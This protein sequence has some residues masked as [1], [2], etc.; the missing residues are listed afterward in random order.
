MSSKK[1]RANN[2]RPR[3][4]SGAGSRKPQN[5]SIEWLPLVILLIVG[6]GIWAGCHG[7]VKQQGNET[8]RGPGT[9]ELPAKPVDQ[10]RN[11]ASEPNKPKS[12]V[13]PS[14]SDSANSATD[15]NNEHGTFDPKQPLSPVDAGSTTRSSRPD[16]PV[17][18]ET[19]T[20]TAQPS[21]EVSSVPN[22]KGMIALTFDAGASAEPVAD[23]L[24]ALADSGSHATFFFTG[25][26]VKKN[27]EAAKSIVAAGHE[28]GNHSWSHPDFT[29]LSDDEMLDQLNQTQQILMSQLGIPGA[30]L[31]RPPFGARNKDVRRLVSSQGYRI[32]YWA[33]DCLDSVKKNITSE[34]IEARVLARAKQGDVVLM[35]CGSQPTADALPTL[36][37]ALKKKG[38]RLVTVG[39]LLK[40]E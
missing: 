34:Q 13:Q 31:F 20:R 9:V 12:D 11:D 28:I 30:A 4:R 38:L 15:T 27:P 5:S 24:K 19:S 16:E 2:T 7:K 8:Y 37:S 36:I 35:H 33:V 10:H 1:P 32:I 23:I 25:K 21:D 6:S 26:W 40:Y 39:E 17:S 22:A 3:N 29:T 18:L 14:H